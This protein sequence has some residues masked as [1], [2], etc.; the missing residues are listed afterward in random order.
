MVNG[1]V[2][3]ITTEEGLGCSLRDGLVDLDDGLVDLGST[4]GVMDG[5]VGKD[6]L[7]SAVDR[8]VV[9]SVS[10]VDLD[11]PLEIDDVVSLVVG[12]K[13]TSSS[14]NVGILKKPKSVSVVCFENIKLVVHLFS[15]QKKSQGKKRKRKKD[16]LQPG[17]RRHRRRP[18]GRV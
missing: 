18:R 1:G 10:V 7:D 16:H 5:N 12:N 15:G 17:P 8:D 2:R 6:I 14:N 3:R 9:G 4:G 11:V 13:G